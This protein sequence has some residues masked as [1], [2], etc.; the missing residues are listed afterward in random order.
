MA[1]LGMG[2]TLISSHHSQRCLYPKCSPDL[3]PCSL[4]W[5]TFLPAQKKSRSSRA[6]KTHTEQ[7]RSAALTSSPYT[8]WPL[9]SQSQSNPSPG[10]WSQNIS[11]PKLSVLHSSLPL[12]PA[13]DKHPRGCHRQQVGHLPTKERSWEGQMDARSALAR[14]EAQSWDNPTPTVCHWATELAWL[15]C[16]EHLS[17]WWLYREVQNPQ[18]QAG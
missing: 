17:P 3:P 18:V 2:Q 14:T 4:S 16:A 7:T 15:R 12:P 5:I 9:S 1:S 13:G 10:K 8:Q 11:I 6:G